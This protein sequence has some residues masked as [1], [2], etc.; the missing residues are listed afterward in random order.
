MK[1]QKGLTKQIGGSA[2]HGSCRSKKICV[3]RWNKAAWKLE[4]LKDTMKTSRLWQSIRLHWNWLIESETPD[5]DF[6]CETDGNHVVQKVLTTGV[7]T[8]G[9]RTAG[10][11][12]MKLGTALHIDM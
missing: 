4:F 6:E 11:E 9:A 3:A 1:Y 7:Q 2:K 12:T 5:A 8:T 10:A